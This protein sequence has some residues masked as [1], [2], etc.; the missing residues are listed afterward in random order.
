MSFRRLVG[1]S[2]KW[3]FTIAIIACLYFIGTSIYNIFIAYEHQEIDESNL[4]ISDNPDAQHDTD[5]VINI[6]LYG[7]DARFDE[8][9]RSDAI[10]ILSIDKQDGQ[11]KLSSLMR[12]SNVII[13]GYGADKLNH[14]YAYGGPELSIKTINQTFDMNISDF[15]S[16]NFDQMATIIDI[17]GGVDVE[18][19]EAEVKDANRIMR[20][21]EIENGTEA[22]PIESAGMQTLSGAQ[23]VAYGRIRYVDSDWGRVERQ[24]IILEQLMSKAMEL[25]PTKYPELLSEVMPNVTTSLT[26]DEILSIGLSI[27]ANGMPEISH[28]T[29]PRHTDTWSQ[30]SR[31]GFNEELATL[32]LHAF[33]Y[34]DVQVEELDNIT[35]EE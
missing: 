9:S 32:K 1:A 7:L 28:A 13:E 8:P 33:I 24:Q 26:A 11:I 17:V 3:L 4:G 18:L 21:L 30:N 22:D 2:F 14:A 34:D 20:D 6:A 16:V 29:F 10:M 25:P 31:I 35:L 27:I 23:A 5:E 12:D 19:S 15:A